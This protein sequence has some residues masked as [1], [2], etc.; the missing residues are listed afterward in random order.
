MGP[1]HKKQ[2]NCNQKFLTLLPFHV[3][4]NPEYLAFSKFRI[5]ISE[6]SPRF[7]FTLKTTTVFVVFQ[8]D[9]ECEIR[10]SKRNKATT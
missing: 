10:T 1:K 5:A 4:K 7:I 3:L 8:K 9:T 6:L 2:N